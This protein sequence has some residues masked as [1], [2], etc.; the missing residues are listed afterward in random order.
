MCKETMTKVTITALGNFLSDFPYN[1]SHENKE[2]YVNNLTSNERCYQ[3]HLEALCSRRVNIIL[4]ISN[5]GDAK[6][7]T[8]KYGNTV[9]I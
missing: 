1:I 9:F 3:D 7:E 5:H 8:Y 2:S 4:Q 6:N